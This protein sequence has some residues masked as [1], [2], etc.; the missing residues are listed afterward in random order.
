MA[1]AADSLEFESEVVSEISPESLPAIHEGDLYHLPS[2]VVQQQER[3]RQRKQSERK[4]KEALMSTLNL[5]PL[6]GATHPVPSQRIPSDS[7]QKDRR[8]RSKYRL[9][10]TGSQLHGCVRQGNP[11]EV[12]YDKQLARGA[13]PVHQR[14]TDE[15]RI[16]LDSD[17]HYHKRL[18]SIFPLSPH[19]ATQG[20][21]SKQRN[22]GGVVQLGKDSGGG[23]GEHSVSGNLHHV[24]GH[25]RW[26]CLPEHVDVSKTVEFKP[27]AD[28]TDVTSGPESRTMGARPKSCA[29]GDDGD[30]NRECDSRASTGGYVSSGRSGGSARIARDSMSDAGDISAS[31]NPLQEDY[32]SI[33]RQ[34]CAAWKLDLR[35]DKPLHNHDD[36]LRE[37][38]NGG[39]QVAQCKA[40]AL[41][42]WPEAIIPSPSDTQGMEKISASSSPADGDISQSICS[43]ERITPFPKCRIPEELCDSLLSLLS[44][45][46]TGHHVQVCALLSLCALN[47]A[48]H[49]NVSDK[50]LTMLLNDP[51]I[52]HRWVGAQCGALVGHKNSV[53]T[54]AFYQLMERVQGADE[55]DISRALHLL[56]VLS[57]RSTLVC[58]LS[59]DFLN[60]KIDRERLAVCHVLPEI[61]P[62]PTSDMVHK[63]VYLSW[64]DSC[65]EV[66]RQA[67]LT[68]V[69]TGNSK[70]IH[71][72]IWSALKHGNEQQMQTGLEKMASL[73]LLTRRLMP[74][75]I[76]CFDSPHTSVRIAAVELAGVLQ[77]NDSKIVSKVVNQLKEGASRL[78]IA[79]YRAL[80]AMHIVAANDLLR[81]MVWAVQ[82]EFNMDVRAEACRSSAVLCPNHPPVVHLLKEML[83]SGDAQI[84]KEAAAEALVAMGEEPTPDDKE[85]RAIADDLEAM[86]TTDKVLSH[87]VQL[88]RHEEVV[89][90]LN[91]RISREVRMLRKA[92]ERKGRQRDM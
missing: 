26:H 68:L 75:Y 8:D 5:T 11:K 45:V 59:A 79:T 83:T 40:V 69:A 86:L 42:A 41:C 74:L 66:R 18:Q 27:P 71:D 73:R 91:T 22:E 20:T 21:G 60:S 50:I 88:D 36:I 6:H 64:H 76:M 78:K 34:W 90:L 44:S 49:S 3:E 30:D 14:G 7:R 38:K 80:C 15:S 9:T 55:A 72:E 4:K 37:M 51:G 77:I 28:S 24:R 81:H 23:P 84:I 43:G 53:I 46:D 58:L 25:R 31:T 67:A 32:R 33:I 89:S 12:R 16:V 56:S 17:L 87:V 61:C 52:E 35:V 48:V 54:K 1:F 2:V 82:L 39:N 57:K 65:P 29:A 62:P 92:Q 70:Y 85:I 13:K 47:I 19:C 10:E 63:L